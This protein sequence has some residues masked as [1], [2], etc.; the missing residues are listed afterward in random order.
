M[1]LF[2]TTMGYFTTVSLPKWNIFNSFSLFVS[3][4]FS[5]FIPFKSLFQVSVLKMESLLRFVVAY[6]S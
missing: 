1:G 5:Y 2:E 3:V 6:R 4:V